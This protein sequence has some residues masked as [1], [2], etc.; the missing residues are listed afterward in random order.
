MVDAVTGG[1]PEG[2]GPVGPAAPERAPHQTTEA[3]AAQFRRVLDGMERS[4]LNFSRHA[5][6]RIE[7]RGL[8]LDEGR[9]QRLEQAVNRAREKGS[10]DSLI[11]IDELALV[12]NIRSQTVVTAIEQPGDGEQIFTNID[13]VV[14]AD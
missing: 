2:V 8:P 10:R 3:Q 11:L 9:V 5:R 6:K 7:Q 4:S 14:I 1:R 13:S 12:V